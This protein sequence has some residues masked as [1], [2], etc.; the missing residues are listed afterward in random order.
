VIALVIR[1]K[2]DFPSI[3]EVFADCIDTSE[4]P[5]ECEKWCGSTIA[6]GKIPPI[7]EL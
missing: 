7:P 6:I 4:S 1:G 3:N 5:N 2:A